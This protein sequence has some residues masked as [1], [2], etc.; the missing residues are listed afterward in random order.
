MIWREHGSLWWIYRL[1]NIEW[2]FILKTVDCNWPWDFRSKS[3]IK[4]FSEVGP[5]IV[6]KI[7]HSFIS[8]EH[9]LHGDYPLL[10]EKPV[11]DGES[12]ETLN[13]LKTTKSSGYDEITPDVIKDSSASIFE[14]M[15]YI[16]NVSIEKA[17][18]PDHL[19]IGKV[20]CFKKWIMR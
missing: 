4:F 12:N 10:Q 15:R 17:I 14:L 19:K 2:N 3:F 1:K 11:T 18:F 5:K 20:N 7:P 13:T 8:F 9:F 16:F 6:F